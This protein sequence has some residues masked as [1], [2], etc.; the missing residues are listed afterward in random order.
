MYPPDNLKQSLRADG[1]RGSPSLPSHLKNLIV[2]IDGVICEDI[3]NE[4]PQRMASAS[5]MPGSKE[6]IN[7]WHDQGHTITLF[8]SREEK[9]RIVT[10]DWLKGHDFKYHNIIFGKPRGGNYHYIDD[11]PIRATQFKS[12]LSDFVLVK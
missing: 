4:E 1:K 8:T 10:V 12:G 6:Q 9:H 7:K 2:D 11:K 3:P 5:E